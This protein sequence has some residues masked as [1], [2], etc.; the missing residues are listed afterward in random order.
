MSSGQVLKNPITR[1]VLDISEGRDTT[2]C[3]KRE[4]EGRGGGTRG[5]RRR[6]GVVR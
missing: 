2:C 4:V 6:A 1:L 5:S 3:T